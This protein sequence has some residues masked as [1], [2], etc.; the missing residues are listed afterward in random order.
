[1]AN[2][3]LINL[4]DMTSV[5]DAI[6]AKGG[7]SD[8]LVFPAGFISAVQAITTGGGTVAGMSLDGVYCV[9][10]DYMDDVDLITI[11]DGTLYETRR[12]IVS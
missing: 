3:Y 12:K 10:I 1:M 8:P 4:E 2:E 5:A 7:T 6:R 11:T 9:I